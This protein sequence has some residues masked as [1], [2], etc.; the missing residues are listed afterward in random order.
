M[1]KDAND[2][3]GLEIFTPS[4]WF[5]LIELSTDKLCIL[6]R[7]RGVCRRKGKHKL[8]EK[9]RRR[10]E[11]E[12]NIIDIVKRQRYFLMAL[13][14][15]LPQMKRQQLLEKSSYLYFYPSPD[16]KKVDKI[17]TSASK[18]VPLND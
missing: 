12:V 9:T 10:L 16:E 6:C 18:V 1:N 8:V 7:K 11:Q 15:L 2:D 4:K 5:N 17:K 14:H 3:S 13:K